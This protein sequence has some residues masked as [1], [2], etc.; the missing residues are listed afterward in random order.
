[1]PTVS[2]ISQHPYADN[3]AWIPKPFITLIGGKGLPPY[4]YV[5]RHPHADRRGLQPASAGALF[6]GKGLPLY[7]MLGRHPYD[8]RW[9]LQPASAGALSGG[10]GLP[11]YFYQVNESSNYHKAF[12][13]FP[14][15]TMNRR[16]SSIEIILSA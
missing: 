12:F 13:I 9:G 1:V 15:K 7:F 5:G 6:G 10:K 16:F 8:D 11:P 2:L 14:H 4:F 3:P